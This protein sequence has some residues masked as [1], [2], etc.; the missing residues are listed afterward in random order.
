MIEEIAAIIAISDDSRRFAR[1]K[2]AG[3]SCPRVVAISEVPRSVWHFAARIQRVGSTTL[4]QRGA[5]ERISR[6]AR[7]HRVRAR[8]HRGGT[9]EEEGDRRR[10]P[11]LP[12]YNS[13]LFKT[14]WTKVGRMC[15]YITC[16]RSYL[17]GQY[18]VEK[19]LDLSCGY[20]AS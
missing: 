4:A 9:I 10:L 18:A 16:A 2:A 11:L 8:R 12:M 20:R 6:D 15:G 19:L 3:S 17:S 5:T 13:E 14:V 7:L 1:M